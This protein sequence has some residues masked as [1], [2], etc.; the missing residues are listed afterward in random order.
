MPDFPVL[1]ALRT[2]EFG[3]TVIDVLPS[4]EPY[5]ELSDYWC[6]MPLRLVHSP[7]SGIGIE[8]GPYALDHNDIEH[9]RAAINSYDNA[10]GHGPRG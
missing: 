2:A 6:T 8:V 1:D 4:L 9:L 5:V 3:R 10:A 7:L